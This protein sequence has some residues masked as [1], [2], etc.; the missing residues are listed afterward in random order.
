MSLPALIRDIHGEGGDAHNTVHNHSG[1]HVEQC[2]S[3]GTQMDI[4][5]ESK[6]PTHTHSV[7]RGTLEEGMSPA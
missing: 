3:M 7:K 2:A 4:P 5:I 6:T 1:R